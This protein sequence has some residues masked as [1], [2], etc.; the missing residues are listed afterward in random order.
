MLAN[1]KEIT[2]NLYTKLT[3]IQG[4]TVTLTLPEDTA[5]FPIAVINPPIETGYPHQ[6]HY[7]LRFNIEAWNNTQYDTM[8]TFDKIKEKLADLGIGL[9]NSTAIYQDPITKK[10]RISG[11][12]ECRFNCITN[13]IEQNF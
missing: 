7:D 8:E 11:N 2:Q 12:F 1:L 9:R 10:Y 6:Q 3:E 5:V 4:L 13:V